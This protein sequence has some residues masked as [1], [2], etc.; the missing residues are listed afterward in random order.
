MLYHTQQLFLAI[1]REGKLVFVRVLVYVITVIFYTLF[2]QAPVS[3][4][5]ERARGT[6]KA[7]LSIF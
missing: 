6:R 7:T 3:K 5:S 2:A 1:E 4:L